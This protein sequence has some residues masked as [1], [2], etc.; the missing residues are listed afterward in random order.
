MTGVEETPSERQETADQR[1]AR[2]WVVVSLVALLLAV[3]VGA[4]IWG[5]DQRSDATELRND[6]DRQR[7]AAL[8]AS[9]FVEEL[10][11][12]D[13]EDLDVQQAAVERLA[14]EEFLTEYLEAFTGEVREQ[15][16]AEQASS[17]VTVQDVFVTSGGA[18][19]V[20]AIVH[21]RSEVSSGGGA[22]AE[23]E[24]Y[25]QVTLVRV[26]DGWRVDEL[27]SLGSRDLSPPLQG[28]AGADSG[29]ETDG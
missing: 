12:Y 10:L 23:L 3:T 28:P 19:E 22:S 8:A 18:D 15:I 11:T 2:R 1:P 25:L 4:V 14:T 20:R 17:T 6:R 21:A 5:A 7:E 13:H 27:T 29:D 24:S 9:G 16:L 26:G